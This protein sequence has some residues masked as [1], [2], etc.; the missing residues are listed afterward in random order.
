MAF[1]TVALLA[2]VQVAA[3]HNLGAAGAGQKAAGM[4]S[5]DATASLRGTHN[6]TRR[7]GAPCAC[8]TSDPSWV[9][10]TRTT[11]KCIFV[12]L[13]AADGNSF[14]AFLN[15]QYGQVSNCVGGN[16]EAT[17]VEANPRFNQ[18]LSAV[19]GKYPGQVTA[20][21]STAAYMCEAKTSFFLDTKDV[22]TNY[23]G[24]S[25]SANHPDV[26]K[27]GLQKVEVPMMN[28]HR[29]LYEKTIPGDTVIVKMDIEG[30]E[31]DILPCLANSNEAT[32][33]DHLFVEVHDP[34]WGMVG[35]TPAGMEAAK[36]TLR[37]KGV[38]IPKYFSPTL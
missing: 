5:L 12:D 8:T 25:L 34:A 4:L 28:L 23:W 20:L 1:A 32:L 38:D 14:A 31:Y 29:L 22:Q 13:G 35:T 6:A 30:A 9:K 10:T 24:S 7:A 16:W 2:L 11:P 3:A 18:A 19:V 15:N 21:S 36:A 17:L 26:K 37:Q 33:V 27:S